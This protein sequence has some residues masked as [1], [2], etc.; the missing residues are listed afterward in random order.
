MT[1]VVDASVA[2]KWFFSKEQYAAEASALLNETPDLIAP[3]LIVA[4]A[5]NVAWK[6]LR[7]GRIA[8]IDLVDIAVNLPRLFAELTGLAALA[9]RATAIAAE[10]DHPVY[11]CFYLAL[12]EARQ[13][14]L[15]TADCRLLAK[16]Q[17]SP[18]AGSATHV[19]DYRPGG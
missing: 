10:L 16:L 7:L 8:A 2:V 11:D 9:P 15:V 5:C 17:G 12:A 1:C 19:V 13:A 6:W 4:E 18:W 14:P 3:E